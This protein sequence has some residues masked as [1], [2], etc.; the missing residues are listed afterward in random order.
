MKGG[1]KNRFVYSSSNTSNDV[2]MSMSMSMSMVVAISVAMVNL[3]IITST[4]VQK[5][6]RYPKLLQIQAAVGVCAK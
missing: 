3:V 4:Y 1:E 6:H 5:R 2:G